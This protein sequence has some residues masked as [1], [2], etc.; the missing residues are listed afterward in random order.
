MLKFGRENVFKDVDNIPPGVRFPAYI[1]EP[2]KQCS[3]ELLIIGREWLTAKAEDSSRR[4]DD[5]ADFI[6]QEIETTLAL[7]LTL[8]PVL[9]DGA[10]LPTITSLPE[11]LRELRE[12]NAIEVRNDPDF[13]HDMDRLIAAL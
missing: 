2:V 11:S 8:M 13:G 6:H 3:A 7:G 9:V 4:L 1:Q 10:S 12:L 5:P